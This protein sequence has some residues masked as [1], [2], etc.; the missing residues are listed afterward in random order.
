MGILNHTSHPHVTN[1]GGAFNVGQ[2]IGLTGLTYVIMQY[3]PPSPSKASSVGRARVAYRVPMSS[4]T[5]PSY[6]HSFSITDNYFILIEQSLRVRL[7]QVIG[8]ILTGKPI[9]RSLK[10]NQD[11]VLAVSFFKR[12]LSY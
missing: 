12:H 8:S 5:E 4:M 2:A 9:V 10:W 11:E 1:D 7:T 6:M 3:P